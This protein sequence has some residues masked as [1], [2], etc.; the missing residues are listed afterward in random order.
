MGNF[1]AYTVHQKLLDSQMRNVELDKAVTQMAV[2]T[3]DTKFFLAK[4]K[5]LLERKR[6]R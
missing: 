6:H 5:K 1:K 3:N 4:V 2:M